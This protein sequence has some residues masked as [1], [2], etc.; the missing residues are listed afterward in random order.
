MLENHGTSQNCYLKKEV[1]RYFID[2][3]NNEQQKYKPYAAI[4]YL[5]RAQ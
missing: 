1:E 3:L 4:N 2:L 5:N